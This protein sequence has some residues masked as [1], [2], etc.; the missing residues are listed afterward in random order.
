MSDFNKTQKGK[1]QKILQRKNVL[2]Q[3]NE[4][5]SQTAGTL[6]NEAK[7]TGED[8]LKQLLNQQRYEKKQ[9]GDLMPGQSLEFKEQNQ[10]QQLEEENK[11]LQQQVFFERRLFNEIQSESQK[12]LEQLRLR[13]KVLAQEAL[14][15]AQ[16]AGRLGEQTKTALMNQVAV[17]S[18]YQIT[19]LQSIIEN[20]V[21]FRKTIDSAINW[22]A[23]S[24]KR[25]QK[26]NYWSMYKKK[27]ASFLLSGE[28]YSQRS[29]G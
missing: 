14:N 4:I 2:E 10:N 27:G 5:G 20:M 1:R 17:P 15:V 8:I 29:A 23:E 24:N 22:M 3:L 25:K 12:K 6:V 9:S 26:K 19:F 7:K 11:K 18:E 28:S 13:L 21:S 16:S